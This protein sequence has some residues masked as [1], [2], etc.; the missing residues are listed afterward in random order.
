MA[1]FTK[2]LRQEIIRD[3]ATRHNGFYNPLLFLE[4]VRAS[5]PEH[6]AYEWF[7]WNDDRAAQEHRLWQARE[8]ARDLKVSFTVQ[9]IGRNK[10]IKVRE[11]SMPLALSPVEGRH[12]GGGYFVSDPDNPE[13][14]E[15]LARQA[16]T[17]LE[18]W[19]RRYEAALLHAGGSKDAIEQQIQ[20]LGKAAPKAA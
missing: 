19:L 13:H 10:A 17:A 4:E 16:A 11:V 1:K 8:F 7:E 6:P 5:G 20:L 9:E 18:S 12:K 15:E 3:F 2:A 14:L